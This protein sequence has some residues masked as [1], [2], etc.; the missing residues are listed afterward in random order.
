VSEAHYRGILHRDIKPSNILFARAGDALVPKLADFGISQTTFRRRLQSHHPDVDDSEWISSFSTVTLFSPRWAAPEQLCGAAEGPAADVYA[1]ALVACFMLLGRPLFDDANARAT[2]TDR[3][4]G[5]AFVSS[6][7]DERGVRGALKRVMLE[8]LR[9]NPRDRLDD[10]IAFCEQLRHALG[11]T[12]MP[13]SAVR[14][15]LDT[16]DLS[17]LEDDVGDTRPTE[18]VTYVGERRV[19][20]VHVNEG[21]DLSFTNA[22]G[23]LTRVRVT[24]LPSSGA[25]HVKGLTCFLAKPGGRP[26]SA[27]TVATDGTLGCRGPSAR[28][29]RRGARSRWTA[30]GSSSAPTRR[31]TRSRFRWP[32]RTSS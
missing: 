22:R 7:L 9:Y 28:S 26:T 11:I 6:R 31:V 17:T 15:R 14:P 24:A 29:R 20:F 3:V 30:D 18:R 16:E 21:L 1:F 10:P 5:D 23:D 12:P 25:L 2:F 13:I 4:S 19:R 32:P 27:V 8:S